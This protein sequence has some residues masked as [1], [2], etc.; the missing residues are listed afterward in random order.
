M[1]EQP[2]IT[3]AVR[4]SVL[5]PL[6]RWSLGPD[7]LLLASE[8]PESGPKREHLPRCLP[9]AEITGIQ[10]RFDP[11]RIDAERH[12]LVI[13]AKGGWRIA[14]P[15]THYRGFADFEDRGSSFYPFAA[16]LTDLVRAANPKAG[17]Q[18]GMTWPSYLGQLGLVV[19][20]FAFLLYILDVTGAAVTADLWIKGILILASLGLLLRWAVRNRPRKVE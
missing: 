10:V 17:L 20:A 13:R 7:A 16:A 18:A 12:H 3:H 19:I 4:N 1:D 11:T 2:T 6:R 5:D 14:I 8:A 9:Y 15:S